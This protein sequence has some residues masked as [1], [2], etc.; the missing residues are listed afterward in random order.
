MKSRMTVIPK[1]MRDEMA[2][3]P[4]YKVCALSGWVIGGELHICEG[5]VTWE[6]AIIFAGEKVQQKWAILPLCAKAHVVDQF[7]DAGTMTK[8]HNEWVALCRA[9]EADIRALDPLEP[10]DRPLQ[11]S[12]LKFLFDRKNYLIKKYGMW[13]VKPPMQTVKN[14]QL[15]LEEMLKAGPGG[16]V[17]PPEC[18]AILIPA[19][20]TKLIRSK[21]DILKKMDPTWPG[22]EAQFIVEAVVNRCRSV[23]MLVKGEG[24]PAVPPRPPFDPEKRPD[25]NNPGEFAT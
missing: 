19:D 16:F 6:H 23:D 9:T 20:L 24:I 2:Q 11:F 14:P 15:T 18:L 10:K 25:N 12:K 21:V 5:R 4:F 7:Q 13:S 17:A 3:D 1:K 22:N 8:E